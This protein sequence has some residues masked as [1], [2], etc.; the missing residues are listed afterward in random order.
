MMSDG[1]GTGRLPSLF[2][3]LSDSTL[4]RKYF[5]NF[6]KEK[7]LKSLET[8]MFD[9]SCFW[10]VYTYHLN[11]KVVDYLQSLSRYQY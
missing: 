5:T 1:S 8:L 7:S 4:N 2:N 3:I 10:L 6:D 11:F 9:I